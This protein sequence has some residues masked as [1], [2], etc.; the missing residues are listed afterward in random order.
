MSKNNSGNIKWYVD[1]V[2]AVH[3]N[4]RSQTIGFITMVTGVAY[5]QSSK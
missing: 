3:K 4:M 2:F 5:V 1:S